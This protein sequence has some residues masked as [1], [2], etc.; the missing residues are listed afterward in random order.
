MTIKFSTTLPNK[1]I[2]DYI[3]H[4]PSGTIYHT[5]N[6]RE[7]LNHSFGY[8]D[9]SLIATD[10]KEKIVGYLPLVQVNKYLTGNRLISLPFSYICGPLA[11]SEAILKKLLL[12]A[13]TLQ[14]TV[15]GQYLEIRS[16]IPLN[17]HWPVA[18]YY[19]S[20]VVNLSTDQDSVWKKID[21]GSIRWAI[22]KAK[23]EGVK[24]IRGRNLRHLQIFYRLNGQNKRNL[25][26]PAHPWRF[27][28]N[29]WQTMPQNTRIYLAKYQNKFVAGIMTLNFRDTIIYAY[30]ASDKSYLKFHPNNLIIWQAIQDGCREGYKYFDFGRSAESDK[31]ISAYKKRWGT[32][33]KETYYYYPKSVRKFTDE[34]QG[35]GYRFVR[36]IWQR[37]PLPITQGLSNI[38]F[39]QFD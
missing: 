36:A 20:Y 3:E 39:G 14:E 15:R 29:I 30:G 31:S 28:K 13:K 6:W 27:L 16:A 23:K 10:E 21:K 34:R 12:K 1:I 2:D 5:P 4:Q 9:L 24:V 35:M 22:N 18:H 33:K 26:I 11:D 37:L 38:L 17:I 32:F 25:G 8:T 19:A 7:I